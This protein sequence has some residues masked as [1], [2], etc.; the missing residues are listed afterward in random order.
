MTIQK[1]RANDVMGFLEPK[2]ISV[3]V[4]FAL[5]GQQTQRFVVQR[6]HIERHD[7]K[8]DPQHGAQP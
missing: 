1:A 8:P 5:V 3:W 7:V 4:R 6:F 2:P